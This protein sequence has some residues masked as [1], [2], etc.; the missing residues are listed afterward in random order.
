ML[1]AMPAHAG[2]EGVR[3]AVQAIVN[4]LEENDDRDVYLRHAGSLA[5]ARIGDQQALTGL[6]DHPS[7][8]LRLAAVVAL[9]VVVA[10]ALQPVLEALIGLPFAARL[11]VV[12][13]NSD[14][15]C[16]LLTP[17]IARLQALAAAEGVAGQVSFIGRRSR[18]VL[19]LYYSAA[20]L[21]VTTPWYEPF[22]I[23]PLEAMACGTP[24]VGSAVGGIQYS[25]VD[26]VTGFLVPPHDPAA[27]AARLAELHANPALAQ[28]L[29]RAGIR[30]VRS[31]F[32]WERVARELA[33]VYDAV[34][35]PAVAARPARRLSLVQHAGARA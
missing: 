21:F 32:T 10:L 4:M 16:P 18:E 28:S 12:G 14:L 19:K 6:A 31:M 3:P 35:R 13:G 9:I 26:G 7:R 22:G 17:E 24:V 30:R 1:A 27:L 15:P 33:E 20:D 23:T 34:R 25:I 11:L 8:A 2:P 29:G 5:L